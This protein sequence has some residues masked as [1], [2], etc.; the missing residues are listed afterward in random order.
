M[1]QLTTPNSNIA[2]AEFTHTAISDFTANFLT[3]IGEG[4]ILTDKGEIYKDSSVRQYKMFYHYLLDFEKT[5]ARKFQFQEITYRFGSEFQSFLTQQDLT[6]NS[7]SNVMKKFKAVMS[8]AFREGLSLWNGTGIKTPTELSTEVTLS[9]EEIKKLRQ[10]ELTISESAQLDM[11]IVQCFTGL[12]YDVLVKF[13]N[14]PLAYIKEYEGSSYIDIISDKTRQQSVIPIGDT[15]T[16]ILTKWGEFKTIA[17]PTM[18][19]NIKTIAEKAGIDNPIVNR[20]TIN[21]KVQETVIPKWMKIKTHTA[22]R[23]FATLLS[24]TDIPNNQISAMTGHTT[25]RQLKMYMR[26]GKLDLI[27]PAIG[28]ELF[29]IQL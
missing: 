14:N 12:R 2:F 4:R 28:H 11:F 18:N 25:E 29:S 8:V 3:K 6:L 19:R 15:V 20:V 9:I 1:H 7:I 10:S 17:E 5:H 24:K 27:L 16:N 26:A 21:G 23:T 22:R 13:L